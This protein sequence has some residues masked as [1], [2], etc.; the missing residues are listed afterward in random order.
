M[1]L[2]PTFGSC[3][4]GLVSKELGRNYIGIEMN[5]EFYD[6]AIPLVVGEGEG[7]K[8]PKEML[9]SPD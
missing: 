3:R 2:D 9:Y 1:V 7:V 8:P 6:K 4:S 5:K